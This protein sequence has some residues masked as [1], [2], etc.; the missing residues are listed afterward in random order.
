VQHKK[1]R[2]AEQ[3]AVKQLEEGMQEKPKEKQLKKEAHT[4]ARICT[5][6]CNISAHFLSE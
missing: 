5:S 3:H 4:L 6:P 1:E 2:T